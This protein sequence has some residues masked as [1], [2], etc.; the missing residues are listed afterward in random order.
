[1]IMKYLNLMPEELK[2]Q[3][4]ILNLIEQSSKYLIIFVTMLFILNIYF[5]LSIQSKTNS[6]YILDKNINDSKYVPSENI[7]KDIDIY[8]KSIS[9]SNENV[10][11]INTISYKLITDIIKIISPF[12]E[13]ITLDFNGNYIL[14]INGVV[15]NESNLNALINVLATFTNSTNINLTNRSILKDDLIEFEIIVGEN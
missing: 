8:N 5:T 7:L 15:P 12:C 1:M 2:R 4:K 6:I 14:T 9:L 10:E 3:N 13:I 11:Y